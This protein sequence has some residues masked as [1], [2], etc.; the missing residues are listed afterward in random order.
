M[1]PFT[2]IAASVAKVPLFINGR[3]YGGSHSF[4]IESPVTGETCW[5]AAC[6]TFA[7]AATAIETAKAAFPAWARTKPAVR[8]YILL[9]TANVLERR[10]SEFA[11]YMHIETG[12]DVEAIKGFV[13]PLASSMLRD[14]AGRIP[15]ICGS[16]PVVEGEGQ[17][18]IV[19]KEPMGVI[20]GMVP[21]TAPYISG[22]R[23]AACALAAG[24]TAVLLSSM[25]T[26]R[27][28]RSIGR[29]FWEAGLPD[30]CLNVI[31]ICRED[32]PPIMNAMIE[33]PA[34]RKVNYTGSI[35]LGKQIAAIC[36]MNLKPSLIDT[37]GQN[38]AIVCADADVPVAVEGVLAGVMLNSYRI[39]MST[40]RILVDASIAEEFMDAL[41][42]TLSMTDAQVLPPIFVKAF[43]K[44]HVESLITSAVECGAELLHGKLETEPSCDGVLS[45]GPFVLANVKPNMR[46]WLEGD[47]TT[48]TAC[49][50]VRSDDE[51]VRIA[52]SVGYG[53]SA[54]VFTK[55]LRKGLAIAKQLEFGAVHIN[56]M[57]MHD[58]PV[59]PY[60]GIK[61]SGWGRFNAEEGLNEYL[62]TKSVTWK[63]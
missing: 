42:Y 48:L 22:I 28:Y 58:E 7:D 50:L 3:D 29:A 44:T 27:C 8:R 46:M 24:N 59:L 33:H 1:D 36:G 57:N 26:P 53:S 16:V 34:I 6:A 9:E 40:G 37:M 55:D 2:A 47:Y 5:E 41:K 54:S 62:V 43:M 31:S 21:S 4:K 18:A 63:D 60:G 10:R 49:M 15:S 11:N 19:F 25:Q 20:L 61:E 12:A 39:Y 35:Y 51:A 30:G 52:N 38:Y 45:I 23:A 13:I 14:I 32:M 17:S 56:G